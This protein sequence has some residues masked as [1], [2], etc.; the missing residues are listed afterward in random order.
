[1]QS[2]KYLFFAEELFLSPFVSPGFLPEDMEDCIEF[3]DLPLWSCPASQTQAGETISGSGSRKWHGST[4]SGTAK[5]GFVE[6]RFIKNIFVL[7]LSS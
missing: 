3:C 7:Q 5:L 4:S 6:Y 1:M 2:K